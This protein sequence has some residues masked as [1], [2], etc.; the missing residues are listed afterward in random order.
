MP[1]VIT[2]NNRKHFKRRIPARYRE[3]YPPSLEFIQTSLDTDSEIIAQQRSTAF[4]TELEQF[5]QTNYSTGPSSYHMG[6]KKLIETA[7]RSG[8]HYKPAK[9]IA[10]SELSEVVSRVLSLKAEKD[11]SEEKVAAILGK[12][13]IPPLYLDQALESY[14][15]F[16]RPDLLNKTPDQVRKW[17]NPRK[18]A[19]SNFIMVC[20]NKPADKIIRDDILTFRS[21]W[22]DRIEQ[23]LSANAANK[24]FTHLKMVLQYIED[25]HAIILNVGGLFKR[26]RF[27]EKESER[28]PFPT[29]FI[30][31]TLLNPINLKNLHEEAR[32]LLY[33][34]A[35]TGAR[36]SE[37]LGLNAE[38]GDI[39]LDTDIPY[40]DI[41]PEDDRTLK[42]RQSKRQIPLV[43][44][45]LLAFQHLPEGFK[46][47][48][49]K[50]DALSAV[51]NK[52]LR[53]N[54]L[55]PTP[56]H[57]VYSLRHSFEDRLTLVEPPEKVQAALMGHK[58]SRERYGDG[59][60]LE[61]K[62][63]WLD[64]IAFNVNGAEYL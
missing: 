6:I 22:M 8:F 18:K 57:T 13:E 47:Y 15:D 14:F 28:P 3:Y 48:Y 16:K 54:G 62:R 51:T 41:R 33:A 25:N 11:I 42:T 35:D 30:Q 19:V 43:G 26:T 49:R 7:R 1:Y 53:N 10:E 55:L 50:S 5:W 45:A 29:D 21:W 64:K 2:R 38:R 34:M 40:I 24:D 31:N 63:K 59:P 60:T 56:E 27:T 46:H 61:Q 52:Y 58:Y 23:G 17:Q 37:L 20:G 12:E 9:D 44:T 36:P 39:R 32:W 4:N